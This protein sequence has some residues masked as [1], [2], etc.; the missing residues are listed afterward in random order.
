MWNDAGIFS[1]W[2]LCWECFLNLHVPSTD[3]LEYSLYLAFFKEG[4]DDDDSS[5]EE[6]GSEPVRQ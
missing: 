6:D 4:R 1:E 5:D 2:G 3:F